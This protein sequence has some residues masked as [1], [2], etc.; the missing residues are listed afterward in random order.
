MWGYQVYSE[1]K[2]H[3]NSPLPRIQFSI[4]AYIP[5]LRGEGLQRWF[6]SFKQRIKIASCKACYYKQQ[7]SLSLLLLFKNRFRIGSNHMLSLYRRHFSLKVK[8]FS[9]VKRGE[10]DKRENGVQ[11]RLWGVT[12]YLL[13]SKT[14]KW[15]DR[16]LVDMPV[17]KNW[18]R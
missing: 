8:V 4:P 15:W 6:A 9:E 1:I 17:S 12:F 3:K 5:G 7:R 2:K 10:V 13:L 18:I 14:N 11:K 16:S